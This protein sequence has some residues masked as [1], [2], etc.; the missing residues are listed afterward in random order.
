V[1]DW[2]TADEDTEKKWSIYSV[3]ERINYREKSLFQ[4]SG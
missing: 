1:P 2:T 4:M 3:N